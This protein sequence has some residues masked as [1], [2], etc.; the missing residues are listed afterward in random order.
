MRPRWLTMA[1]WREDWQM[2][3]AALVAAVVLWAYIRQEQT[4]VITLNVPLEFRSMPQTMRLVRRPPQA[5]EVKFQ[6]HRSAMASL[7]P[8]SVRIVADLSHHRGRR[9]SIPLKPDDVIRPE[10]ATV[11]DITPSLLMM[12]FEPVGRD[13]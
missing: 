12:E 2:R 3:L 6:V 9:I 7:S 10:G 5:V 1:F 4:M 13:E 11:L 8:E